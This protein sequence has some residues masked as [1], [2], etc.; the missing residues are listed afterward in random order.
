MTKEE[1]KEYNRKYYQANKKK[2]K[3]EL[4][5]EK[6]KVVEGQD[7]ASGAAN[8]MTFVLPIIMVIFTLTS[9]SIFSL[10]IIT[11]SLVSLATQPLF[12]LIFK[13]IDERKAMKEKFATGVNYSRD[14]LYK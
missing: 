6:K 7:A 8:I 9:S 4:A 1:R 2:I 10:Y 13:A 11:S 12:N 3:D 5:A 14:N